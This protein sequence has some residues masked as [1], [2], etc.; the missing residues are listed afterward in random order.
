MANQGQSFGDFTSFNIP[1]IVSESSAPQ[2][3]ESKQVTTTT[4]N[5]IYNHQKK[6][7]F[8]DIKGT[9]LVKDFIRFVEA[10]KE[11]DVETRP[12]LFEEKVFMST[13]TDKNRGCDYLNPLIYNCDEQVMQNLQTIFVSS[14]QIAVMKSIDKALDRTVYQPMARTSRKM[15]EDL[16]NAA[17]FYT[18]TMGSQFKQLLQTKYRDSQLAQR[19][20]ARVRNFEVDKF[21]FDI[22]IISMVFNDKKQLIPIDDP[23]LNIKFKIGT[24]EKSRRKT[25]QIENRFVKYEWIADKKKWGNKIEVIPAERCQVDNLSEL[26]D[27]S[28]ARIGAKLKLIAS[29]SSVRELAIKFECSEEV[30]FSEGTHEE[31]TEELMK[32]YNDQEDVD[33]SSYPTGG[34]EE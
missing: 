5:K 28:G 27:K 29:S 25:N 7:K 17:Q 12:Y 2:V 1:P 11:L 22:P 18:Q 23:L 3:E 26:F 32:R 8:V 6:N 10:Y 16:F 30:W 9:L 4:K 15:N 21:N 19:M 24:E 20:A 14:T 31:S 13:D 34:Y 33:S